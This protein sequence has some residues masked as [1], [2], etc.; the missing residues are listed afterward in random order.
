MGSIAAL[1]E[2]ELAEYLRSQRSTTQAE[3]DAIGAARDREDISAAERY[4]ALAH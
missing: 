1:G 4:S 2:H 3:V